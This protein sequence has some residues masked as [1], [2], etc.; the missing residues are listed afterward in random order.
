MGLRAAALS[1]RMSSMQAWKSVPYL[2]KSG[3]LLEMGSASSSV[4]W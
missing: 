3:G 1:V 2:E 4:R